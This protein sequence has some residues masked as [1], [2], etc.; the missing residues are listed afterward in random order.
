M[1]KFAIGLGISSALLMAGCSD[2]EETADIGVSES[3]TKPEESTSEVTAEKETNEQ[4]DAQLESPY[5]EIKDHFDSYELPEEGRLADSEFINAVEYE[6]GYT[7]DQDTKAM[8]ARIHLESGPAEPTEGQNT[9]VI[10][11]WLQDAS[12]IPTP[13]NR[14]KGN[15][16][17]Q[18]DPI[19]NRLQQIKELN[20]FEPLEQWVIE[21]ENSL[22]KFDDIETEQERAKVYAEAY[23][24]LEKMSSL[25]QEP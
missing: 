9:G 12:A 6:N 7:F 16:A 4:E 3:E 17:G 13:E 5:Q 23:E 8:V 21:T 14:T 15:A 10:M 11:G 24:R 22:V 19:L 25:I 20:D 2:S 1:K 18:V